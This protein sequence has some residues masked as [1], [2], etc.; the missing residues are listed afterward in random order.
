MEHDRNIDVYSLPIKELELR[1]REYYK[2]KNTGIKCIGELVKYD[3]SRLLKLLGTV[4]AGRKT[5]NDIKE[6]LA[7]KD[8]SLGM[9]TQGWE[10]PFKGRLSSFE[11]NK[12]M[13]IKDY[14][15]IISNSNKQIVFDLGK[16]C[17]SDD[18][19]PIHF[20]RWQM[21][22]LPTTFES[23][24][25][26]Y[27][28]TNLEGVFKYEISDTDWKDWHMNFAHE[29]LFACYGSS[30][31]AQD[32][33]Q[34]AEHQ[35]LA[36]LRECLID[37]NIIRLTEDS[38]VATPILIQNV[39]RCCSIDIAPNNS[40]GRPNGLY[41]NNFAAAPP[42]A[43]IKATRRLNLTTTSNIIAMESP[44]LGKGK[45]TRD[46]IEFI[47]QTA[48]TGFRAAVNET[49]W[50]HKEYKIAIHT[51]YWGCG[52]YGGNRELMSLLQIIAARLAKVDNLVFHT[53][54]DSTSYKNALKII[55]KLMLDESL[56]GDSKVPQYC[57]NQLID[58]IT[59]MG[60]QWGVGNGT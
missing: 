14:P 25:D 49:K 57:T 35:I 13:L 18:L 58:D 42:E 30:L 32:E 43:V 47:L 8:L 60:F 22:A 20:S 56:Q 4:Y 39:E 3:E 37:K 21:Q 15:P 24:C 59:A 12:W 55:D 27:K 48:Y 41:G 7:K 16:K 19:F 26:I 36:S 46:Q 34:V 44:P 38:G 10:S 33:M 40:E 29:E 17:H 5:L 53:G 6:A 52:A 50:A 28:S 2:V 54:N 9:E 51:G 1:V 31:F 45:Y 11:F 23:I